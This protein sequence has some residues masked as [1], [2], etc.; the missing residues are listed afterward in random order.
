MNHVLLYPK[1][2]YTESYEKFGFLFFND[3]YPE[4]YP[5]KFAN[6]KDKDKQMIFSPTYEDFNVRLDMEKFKCD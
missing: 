1:E 6:I 3:I 2:I 4:N 5:D